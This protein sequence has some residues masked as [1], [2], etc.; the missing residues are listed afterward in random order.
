MKE[1]SSMKSSRDPVCI[2]G[3]NESVTIANLL[4]AISMVAVSTRGQT[5]NA[6]KVIS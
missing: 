6:T 2:L 4:S 3:K 5:E 1:I